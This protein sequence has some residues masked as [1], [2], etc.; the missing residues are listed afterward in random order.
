MYQLFKDYPAQ[1]NTKVDAVDFLYVRRTMLRE[2]TRVTTYYKNSNFVVKGDHLI[3]QLLLQL[4]VS[5]SRD[6]ESYVRACGYETE[7]LARAFRLINP[8]VSDPKP[9][10]GTFYNNK[11]KEFI[12]IHAT[13]FDIEKAYSQWEK[14][15]PIKVHSHCFTDTSCGLL[16]GEYENSLNEGGYSVISINLPMLALQYRAWIDK[17]RQHQE[18]KSQ[19]VNFIFQYPIN[20]M[21]H[22]HIDI[23]VINRLINTYRGEPIAMHKRVHPIAVVNHDE[24]L[25]LVIEKRIDYIKKG[26]FKFDQLFTIFNCLKRPD[27]LAVIRP[28]DLAP[29][30]SVKWV[31][32]MQ[33]LNYFQFFLE[34]RR[35]SNSTYNTREVSR[36]QRDLRNL[37]TD[38]SHYSAAHQELD[39]KITNILSLI[40]SG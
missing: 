20:N 28:L 10:H 37:N 12:I 13:Q 36:A 24:R 3:N 40:D 29:V 39:M 18:V 5:L 11:T 4:N 2:L 25:D 32:E 6:L 15:V 1:R 23:A 7:R 9:H 35:D 8:V 14:I 22:R 21:I 31:L 34:V 26:N 16:N 30:R 19:S 33:V 27:W 38:T 17:V